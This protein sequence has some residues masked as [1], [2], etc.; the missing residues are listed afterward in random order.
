MLTIYIEKGILKDNIT[1]MMFLVIIFCNTL[2]GIIQEIKAK[3]IINKI[4]LMTSPTATVL[5]NGQEIEIPI[6]DIVLDDIIILTTGK[7][8]PADCIMV[9]GEIEANESLLTGESVPLKKKK[10]AE[11]P[12]IISY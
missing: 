12:I 2:I 5:R 8:I 11:A 10:G 7:Q 1:N 9:E 6:T 4:K 3:M